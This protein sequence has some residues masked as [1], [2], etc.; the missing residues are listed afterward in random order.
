MPIEHLIF[1]T[2]FTPALVGGFNLIF[3]KSPNLRDSVTLL[4]ALIT[5]Y[6]SISILLGFDG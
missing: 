2:I 3:D 4:G 6:F 1:L 5:F